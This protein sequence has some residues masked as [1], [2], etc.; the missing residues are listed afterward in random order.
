[1]IEWK[2][3]YGDIN[4]KNILNSLLFK[5]TECVVLQWVRS[6]FTRVQCASVRK[7]YATEYLQNA[8]GKKMG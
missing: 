3:L 7:A 6:T 4:R 2:K 8:L 1:M 5:R